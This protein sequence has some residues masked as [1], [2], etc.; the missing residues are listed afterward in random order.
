MNVMMD[1]RK[2]CNHPYLFPSAEA[3]A[4]LTP[5]GRYEGYALMKASGKF[6]LLGKMLEKL[7]R[8]GHR[9]L[10]F[11]QVLCKIVIE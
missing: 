7:R 1:L 10:I 9:V 5:Q 11:S 6:E 4:P 2:C 3:E 8:D